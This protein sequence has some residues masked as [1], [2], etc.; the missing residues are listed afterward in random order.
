M[1][2]LFVAAPLLNGCRRLADDMPECRRTVMH[3][4]RVNKDEIDRFK[5]SGESPAH[6]E[7]DGVVGD[8]NGGLNRQNRWRQYL[9][10]AS[11]SV[12]IGGFP[13]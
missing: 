5:G 1:R 12:P 8:D 4:P 2:N 11:L 10:Y 9:R 7:Q 3:D 6:Q 13:A